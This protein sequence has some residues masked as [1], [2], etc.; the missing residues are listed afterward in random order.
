M[1]TEV[2]TKQVPIALEA[3]GRH[4]QEHELPNPIS[5]DISALAQTIRVRVPMEEAQ[6]AW[7]NTLVLVHEHNEPYMGPVWLK[8]T[9]TVR[10]PDSE[11]NFELRGLRHTPARMLSSVPA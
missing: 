7:L 4:I 11:I 5:I 10:L 3:L 9:W 1:D 2:F 8:T 6:R